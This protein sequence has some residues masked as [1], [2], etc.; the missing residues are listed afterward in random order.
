MRRLMIV[1][2]IGVL[3]LALP[4]G[5]RAQT[6]TQPA[7]TP[8][9]SNPASAD[10]QATPQTAAAPAAAS[11]P[12]RSLF[13]VTPR[14]FQIGGRLSNIAGDPARFQRYQ[15]LGNGLVFSDG[16]YEHADV[17]ASSIFHATANNV[18]WEDQ[19]YTADYHRTGKFSVSGLWD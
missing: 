15:D 11:E 5:A 12:S 19:R 8:P 1:Q 18:G 3:G 14:Q 4:A 17:A 13:E 2:L 9:A 6:A 7:A 10:P 16:R